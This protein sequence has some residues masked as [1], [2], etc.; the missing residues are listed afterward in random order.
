M[1]VDELNS[2]IVEQVGCTHTAIYSVAEGK[3]GLSWNNSFN[4]FKFDSSPNKLA[5]APSGRI[6]FQ[7]TQSLSLY[8]V[9]PPTLEEMKKVLRGT[10]IEQQG[11][12]DFAREGGNVRKIGA[13][14]NCISNAREDLFFVWKED[15]LQL[16]SFGSDGELEVTSIK[17]LLHNMADVSDITSSSIGELFAKTKV[18]LKNPKIK[19]IGS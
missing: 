4:W 5:I 7:P 12:T 9:S 1:T 10:T 3:L 14:S 6:L 2:G 15:D 18:I 17:G 19:F 11:T 13:V 16:F 8:S